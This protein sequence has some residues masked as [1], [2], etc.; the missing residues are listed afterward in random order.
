MRAVA[1]L[2]LSWQAA[3]CYDPTIPSGGFSCVSDP[4]CPSGLTCDPCNHLC[5]SALSSCPDLAG[6]DQAQPPPDLAAPDLAPLAWTAEPSGV[7]NALFAVWCAGPGGDVYVVG[8]TGLILR[9]SGGGWT[10]VHDIGSDL[11]GVWGSDVHDL[12][13]SGA[14]P[15]LI[16]H[17]VDGAGVSWSSVP[18]PNGTGTRLNG[19]WGSDATN[20]YVVGESSASILSGSAGA[21]GFAAG[22]IPKPLKAVWG[23]SRSDVYVVGGD[24]GIQHWNGSG[25]VDQHQ[26]AG[27]GSAFHAVW[28]AGAGDVYV[29]GAA[30]AL[31]HY[32]GSGWQTYASGTLANLFGAWG[33]AGNDVYLVGDG[34]LILHSGD[35]GSSW[36]R[37]ETGVAVTLYG[38]AGTGSGDVWVVGDRG[39]IL[40]HP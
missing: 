12:Y 32:S 33:A 9:R 38:I 13:A 37:E 28:G 3:G 30:G 34:G 17:S 15:A 10:K 4:S 19:A 39:T 36:Q 40:H 21:F 25:W 26:Q 24:Y 18:L 2:L 11:N 16:L 20:V 6:V 1:A 14:S 8:A 29:A 31:L 35:G 5:V 23:S 27:S 7:Q 22:A